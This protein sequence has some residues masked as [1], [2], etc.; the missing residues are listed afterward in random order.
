MSFRTTHLDLPGR[1]LTNSV[2]NALHDIAEGSSVNIAYPG[3]DFHLDEADDGSA[4]LVLLS[5]GIGQTPL[6]SM[7]RAQL[8]SKRPI[9]Y[10]TVAKNNTT[11]AFKKDVETLA[12][13]NSNLTFKVFHSRPL[14]DETSGKDYDH[15]G[16]L[17]VGKVKGEIY[18]DNVAAHY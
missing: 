18:I 8:Y 5:A 11:Q 6:Y 16:R 15:E 4:P 17:S 2:S 7:L 9:S 10:V 14:P 13:E 3:G 1:A 12:K